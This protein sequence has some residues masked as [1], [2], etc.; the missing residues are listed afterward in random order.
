MKSTPATSDSVR[1]NVIERQPSEGRQNVASRLLQ[2]E[3]RRRRRDLIAGVI[4]PVVLLA[5]WQMASQFGVLDVRLFSEPTRVLEQGWKMLSTGMLT[6]DSF[7]TIQRLVI[8]YVIGAVVGIA[9]GLVLGMSRLMRAAL[10]PTLAALYA[11]PKIAVLPLLLLL[12]GLGDVPLV[13]MVFF[14]VVFPVYISTESGVRSLDT[15]LIEAGRSCGATG[16]TLFLRVIL[17]GSLSQIFA[18]LKVAAGL[19]IVVIIA[20]EF[21]SAN[22][23]LGQLI[24]TSWTLL[25][26]DPMF[27]GIVLAALIGA[28]FIQII[29]TLEKIVIPW[30]SGA[31]GV[32]KSIRRVRHHEV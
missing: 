20:A 23:G 12:F 15:Q 6:G 10:N 21:V 19:G 17:P 5:A 27:V 7:A 2:R 11:V 32:T 1:S 25:Q 18:G 24:W 22:N 30:R 3:I 9:F 13:I 14:A 31:S 28:V 16:I 26:P 8:G 29:V 4:T